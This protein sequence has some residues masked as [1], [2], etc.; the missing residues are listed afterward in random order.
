MEQ[1]IEIIKKQLN[2]NNV[3]ISEDTSFKDDLAIDSLD[4]AELIMAFE[5]E[6]GI[7]IDS[8]EC[9]EIDS[10]IKTVGDAVE[11]LKSHGVEF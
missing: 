4:L 7:E 1:V 9:E 8:K 10:K 2:L 6:F 3:E 11:L 5:D